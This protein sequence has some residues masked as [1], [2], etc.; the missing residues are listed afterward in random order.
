MNK[1][2]NEEITLVCVICR[3][4]FL[5]DFIVASFIIFS[6]SLGLRTNA[7]NG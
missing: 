5:R 6:K 1:M 7:L 2:K 3:T 4:I